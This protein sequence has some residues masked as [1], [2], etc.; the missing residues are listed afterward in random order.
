MK[1]PY[2]LRE[3]WRKVAWESRGA[4][5]DLVTFVE[6]QVKIASDPLFGNMQDSQSMSNNKSASVRHM[7]PIR[8]R[9]TF[10]INVT[11]VEEENKTHMDSKMKSSFSKGA[12]N[13]VYFVNKIVTHWV[14]A[15]TLGLG[16]KKTR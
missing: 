13:V 10:A 5:T 11:S 4:F 9:S 3:K 2:K 1:L 15:H 8:K 7:K 14:N 12:L 16:W 6:K